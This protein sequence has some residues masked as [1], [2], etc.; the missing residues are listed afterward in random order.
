MSLWAHLS[1]I[2]QVSVTRLRII[3]NTNVNRH[4]ISYVPVLI[5]SQWHT[6]LKINGIE[7]FNFL[8]Y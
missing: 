7:I 1:D 3:R 8:I 6:F 5:L 2:C 4:I